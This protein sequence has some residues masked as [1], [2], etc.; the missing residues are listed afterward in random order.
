MRVCRGLKRARDFRKVRLFYTQNGPLN[1]FFEVYQTESVFASFFS[2]PRA[3]RRV[4]ND[5]ANTR[6]GAKANYPREMFVRKRE[7]KDLHNFSG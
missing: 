6:Q 7:E 1:F 3:S 4:F 5:W 2:A